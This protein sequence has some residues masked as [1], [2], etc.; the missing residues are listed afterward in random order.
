MADDKPDEATS[1]ADILS[2]R[3]AVYTLV[4][5]LGTILFGFNLF[6]VSA[7]MPSIEA[8]I[9]GMQYYSWSFS[10]FSVGSVIGAASAGPVREAFGDR[11]SYA[12]AG[13]VMVIGLIGAA[14]AHDMLVLVFWRFIQGLGGGAV[15]AQSYGLVGS[16]YPEHLRGR[17][18][19]MVSTAWGVATAI[20]PGFGG[21][22]AEIGY[23]PGAFWSLGAVSLVITIAAWVIISPAKG[24]G[25]L[26]AIPYR[27]L[28]LL[29]VSV[30][31]LS[32]TSNVDANWARGVLI[33]L[34]AV[35]AII[36]FRLDSR[37]ENTMFPRRAMNIAG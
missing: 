24:H 33:V 23:W 20:G 6:V 36:A 4:L 1:W 3:L 27:R 30:L 10:L 13:L 26:G 29:A 31:A 35:L 37:A 34:S 8:E 16:M 28:A 18:L 21:I 7:I 25:K 22:F 12:G 5:T 2:G 17:V 11:L 32:L 15:A 9:G 19:S 14:V